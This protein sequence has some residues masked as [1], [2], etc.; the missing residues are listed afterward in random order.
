MYLLFLRL[1]LIKYDKNDTK[2]LLIGGIKI[3][4][5]EICSRYFLYSNYFQKYQFYLKSFKHIFICLKIIEEKLNW[6]MIIW[7]YELEI[8]EILHDD[9]GICC[10]LYSDENVNHIKC[11]GECFIK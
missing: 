9:N 3:I 8:L 4:K 6:C 10:G 5:R 11:I 2:I 7:G 1:H